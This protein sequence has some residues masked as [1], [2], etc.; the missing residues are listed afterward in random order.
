MTTILDF[1]DI[2]QLLYI[3]Q[4]EKCKYYVLQLI[5]KNEKKK[6]TKIC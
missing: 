3:Y 6:T 5:N 4:D 2:K 1:Y